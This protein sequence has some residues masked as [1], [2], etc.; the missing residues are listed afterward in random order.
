[1]GKWINIGGKDALKKIYHF[2]PMRFPDFVN[3][4]FKGD[5][6]V[7]GKLNVQNNTARF[8]GVELKASN[9]IPFFRALDGNIKSE[10]AI[11]DRINTPTSELNKLVRYNMSYEYWDKN[12]STG[13]FQPVQDRTLTHTLNPDFNPSDPTNPETGY[14]YRSS[15]VVQAQGDLRVLNWYLRSSTG[16]KNFYVK[17]FVGVV[18]NPINADDDLVWQ[19]VDDGDVFNENC[20]NAGA[21]VVNDIQFPLNDDYKQTN[22]NIYT[23]WSWAQNELE[24]EAGPLEV[25]PSVFIDYPYVVADGYQTYNKAVNETTQRIG[26]FFNIEGNITL[27]EGE[28]WG[29]YQLMDAG[30][31]NYA[32]VYMTFNGFNNPTREGVLRVCLYDAGTGDEL[33]Q[34]STTIIDTDNE[35]KVKIPFDT[36]VTKEKQGDVIVCFMLN[37]LTNGRFISVG[38]NRGD[39]QSNNEFLFS[40]DY[41]ATSEFPANISAFTNVSS[42]RDAIICEIAFDE[43]LIQNQISMLGTPMLLG[44]ES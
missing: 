23:F 31:Y 2:L 4:V 29:V 18:D 39:A 1:L 19:S 14:K 34:G 32:R 26:S 28:V 44:M 17:M 37:D 3:A 33:G 38:R 7:W 40:A 9:A 15:I 6:T 8:K 30:D 11:S 20:F 24:L 22:Q 27:D 35:G 16:F 25:A 10:I 43:S 21:D 12:S 41:S 42:E 5:L 36:I 13:Q